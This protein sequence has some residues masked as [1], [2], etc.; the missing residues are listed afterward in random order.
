MV[1][2][3]RVALVIAGF[4][5]VLGAQAQTGGSVVR[6]GVLT[7]MNGPFPLGSA[8]ALSWRQK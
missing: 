4:A 7:D 1:D 8:R 3:M 6:I 2:V 5:A